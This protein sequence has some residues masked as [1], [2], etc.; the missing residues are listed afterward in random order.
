MAVMRGQSLF[1]L[2]PPRLGYFDVGTLGRFLFFN[3]YGF[4]APDDVEILVSDDSSCFAF[5]SDDTLALQFHIDATAD[6]LERWTNDPIGTEKLLANG[7]SQNRLLEEARQ[8]EDT[9]T[10]SVHQLLMPLID[11]AKA[12]WSENRQF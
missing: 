5:R 3:E 2:N 7:I 1:E 9:V 6:L 11:I 12:R 8:T 4:T 10:H